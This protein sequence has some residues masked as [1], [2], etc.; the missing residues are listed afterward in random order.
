MQGPSPFPL[1]QQRK[2]KVG[3]IHQIVWKDAAKNRSD[4]LE[5]RSV[6]TQ[7]LQGEP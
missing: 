6:W 7:S 4:K 1:S 2:T 5:T 3:K